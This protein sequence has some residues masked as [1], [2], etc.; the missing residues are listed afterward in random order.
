MYPLS[1]I[2]FGLVFFL[3][4]ERIAKKELFFGVFMGYL[5]IYTIFFQ[6]GYQLYPEFSERIKAY[7]GL[8]AFWKY[9]FQVFASFAGFFLLFILGSPFF[10]RPIFHVCEFRRSALKQV[11]LYALLFGQYGYVLTYSWYFGDKLNYI[12]ALGAG[13]DG[14]RLAGLTVFGILFKLSIIWILLFYLLAREKKQKPVRDWLLFSFSCAATISICI[15]LGNRTDLIAVATGITAYEVSRIRG[16]GRVLVIRRIFILA[17]LF[18]IAF[19][20]SKL[21]ISNRGNQDLEPKA[22]AER[23]IVNDYFA[24]SHVLITTIALEFNSFPEVLR[25]NSAN[26]LLGFGYPLLQTTVME[27]IN[28]GVS[29]RTTGYGFYMLSEG[30][31]ALGVYGFIYNSIV[32][33]FA[34]FLLRCFATTDSAFFNTFCLMLLC[35]YCANF[36]RT[37]T[38]FFI[39]YIYTFLFPAFLLF[40]L[41]TGQRI[42]GII[43][44]R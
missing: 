43:R 19:G 16:I 17:P 35:A 20:L 11:L 28:P 38:S 29:S 8:D 31:L 1:T 10:K 4:W 23:I 14:Q 13:E 5:F 12:S 25:S 2:T 24:P 44:R 7:F 21:A 40:F 41:A 22:L 33:V 42:A 37:Q 39:K 6:F 27:Q 26:A 36:S 32:I 9:Q 15:K 30:P 34:Y 3:L 18:V